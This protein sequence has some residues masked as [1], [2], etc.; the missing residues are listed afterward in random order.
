MEKLEA[1]DKVRL[2]EK[3]LKKHPQDA[4][5]TGEVLEIF[6][7][8]TRNSIQRRYPVRVLLSNGN[9]GL[10][11]E[12][13]LV[14]MEEEKEDPHIWAVYAVFDTP[15]GRH[16]VEQLSLHATKEGAEAEVEIQK[17]EYPEVACDPNSDIIARKLKIGA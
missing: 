4:H 9:E 6:G 7:E 5:L 1:G 17:K 13:E 15:Q 8:D 14:L 12:D 16:I 2:S 11:R 10:A 3:Y